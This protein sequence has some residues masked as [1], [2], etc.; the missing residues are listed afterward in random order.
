MSKL[1]RFLIIIG[2]VVLCLVV[3][4]PIEAQQV[5]VRKL[6]AMKVRSIGPAGMS[7]RVT[8]IDAV[9]SNPDIIY[10]GTASG[11]VWKSESGGI[12][13]TPI[14]DGEAIIS[15]GAVAIDQGN[16]DVIWVGTGEGNPRNSQSSGAGIYKS[17]DGGKN[18]Q[19]MGLAQTKAIHRIIIHRDNP[20]MVYVAALGSAWGPNEERGVYKTHDGGKSWNKILYVN[21]QTGAADLVVD[22]GNPNKLIAAMWEYGRKPWFFK[23]GGEGSGMYVTFDGGTTWKQRTDKDGLPKGELGRMGLAIAPSNP[24]IVYALIES[25]KLALYKSTDAGFKWKKVSDK[26]VGNRPFYYADIYVDPDNE[27]TIY[28]LWT[29]TSRSIDGGKTF[30]TILN[31]RAGVHPD[32]HAFWIDPNN[33]D[34]IIDGNDGGLNISR[35]GGSNWR[36]VENLPL[37]QFYHINIDNDIPYNVYG[38]MQDNGSWQGPS[39]IY[40][41][42]GIRN[43]HWQELLFGDG[44][45]VSPY[46]KDSRFGYAMYQGGNIHKYD[47]KTGRAQ[48][49]QP[50]S[51]DSS[52]RLRFNWNAGLA[53]DPFDDCTVYFGSQFVHKSTNCGD[54]W[55]VISPD[56]TTND[57]TKQKQVQSGGLTI[58]ATQAENFTSI[59]S[60]APSSVKP[61]VIWVGTDDGNLQLTKDG[62]KT[63]AN[64]IGKIKRVPTGS[65]IP[66]IE[67]SPVNEGEA[68]VVINNY[69]RNDW[70]PYVLRTTDFG[71][72]WVNLTSF[73]KVNGYAL[74]IV[75]DP[76][77]PKLLFLG[78]E[79]GLYF[80]IDR[81]ISWTKW[82]KDFPSVSTMDLKIHPRTGDLIIG[83]FGRAAY[84]LDD[85]APLRE[86]AKQG[87][88]LLDEPFH[89]FP[90]QEAMITSFKSIQGVRF[91]ADAHYKGQNRSGAAMIYFYLKDVKQ[92]EEEQEGGKGKSKELEKKEEQP[93]DKIK[94]RY[95]GK[96]RVNVI[97]G[98]GDTIRTYSFKPDTGL[99]RTYW[100]M[101]RDL[102][103]LPQYGDMDENADLPGGR[104]VMPGTYTVVLTYGDYSGSTKIKVAKDLREDVSEADLKVKGDA[105][106]ALMHEAELATASFERLK[107]INK[108]V[109]RV[110]KHLQN[111]EADSVRKD[112]E[113]AG[114]AITKKT[115]ELI[116]LYL[117]PEDFVGYDHITLRIMDVLWTAADYIESS[118]GAPTQTALDYSS[119]AI[120][121]L[122]KVVARVNKL[123]AEDWAA[124]QKKV[125]AVE[126]SL[127][128]TFVPIEHKK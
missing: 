102:I 22:P 25:E 17:L 42:G 89:V 27:N 14:F 39:R 94:E 36:F 66:H 120:E 44:F 47:T 33:S 1:R 117:E 121:E 92:E 51:T 38:G 107:D 72:T 49:I 7:G 109:A 97:S 16:P 59:I 101:N 12:S 65:W 82:A 50:V 79:H 63:W 114:E 119:Y 19:F 58:D 85:I 55:E 61:G 125:E 126:V 122:Y 74:A 77:E 90:A 3:C 29:Y 5:D 93:I 78:T 116:N 96:V 9:E 46:P 95:K 99:N 80:S 11:G 60:I 71:N 56:L 106:Q 86:L 52:L 127:F 103:Q 48:Y 26:N 112:I 124:Y 31:Y 15:I 69:R 83:T 91:T 40:Q 88:S 21:D 43:S 105:H 84:I 62:G 10:I 41:S 110:N 18:W 118:K 76:V 45:D 54:S 108:T 28:N 57:T 20:D 67:A 100:A 81:G 35:D 73:S 37:G 115:S 53:Q 68:Y 123:V 70:K 34:Y 8:S 13:W 128:K 98:A 30:K 64:K 87:V 75:Q 104:S 2:C 4:H 24:K 113:K 111:L 32:H 6:K 23:S